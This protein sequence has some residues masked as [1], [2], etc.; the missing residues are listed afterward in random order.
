MEKK[1]IEALGRSWSWP[2]ADEKCHKVVFDWSKDLNTVYPH[3]RAFECVVQAGG[4]MGVWPWI[5][6]RKFKHVL[7]FEADPVCFPF[8]LEN[9][10]NVPNVEAFHAALM[11]ESSTVHMAND[12]PNNL[13]AQ[14]VQPG[15]SVLSTT[16]DSMY[17][18]SCDLI[19]LD[20]EGAEMKAL[21]GAVETIALFNPV[22]VVEDKGLSSRFGSAKGDI[23]KWL[24]AQFGYKVVARPHR[25]VVLACT[26]S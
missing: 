12:Q 3:C 24:G 20:I 13:G 22:I 8:L 16:I 7:T 19:C 4:N 2:A 23:E 18:S 14:Y 21:K 26:Y 11:D 5:L 9:T 1:V 10:A 6:A 15:G 17:L 25:D